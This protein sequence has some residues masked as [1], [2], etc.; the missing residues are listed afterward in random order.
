MN[1]TATNEHSW[2][3]LLLRSRC[4][5]GSK[6]FYVSIEVV[7]VPHLMCFAKVLLAPCH[8]IMFWWPMKINLR[9]NFRF[10]FAWMFWVSMAINQFL[11]NQTFN[12]INDYHVLHN[13]ES[14]DV[15]FPFLTRLAF[16]FS[17]KC[18]CRIFKN[19]NDWWT[20]LFLP[21]TDCPNCVDE[22]PVPPNRWTMPLLKLGEKRY[23]LGIFFKVNFSSCTARPHKSLWH[24]NVISKWNFCKNANK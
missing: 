11:E 19:F 15:L 1:F 20:I 10:P 4:I 21:S 24:T 7:D 13:R 23:Y 2:H 9:I 5:Q 18:F 8:N 17:I 14:L 12:S 22:S 3:S 16:H 6:S